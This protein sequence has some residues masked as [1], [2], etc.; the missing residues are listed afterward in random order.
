MRANLSR[1][2]ESILPTDV[3][4]RS[5]PRSSAGFSLRSSML[6]RKEIWL[7]WKV[8]LRNG[9]VLAVCVSHWS[10]SRT[11]GHQDICCGS[12]GDGWATRTSRCREVYCPRFVATRLAA[13]LLFDGAPCFAAFACPVLVIKRDC[14]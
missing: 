9:L 4:R 2:A 8:C 10:A 5:V 11:D 13:T 6:R 12:G 14:S 1:A 7:L 3:P